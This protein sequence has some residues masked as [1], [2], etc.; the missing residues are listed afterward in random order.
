M[1]AASIKY[2]FSTICESLYTEE[3]IDV[4]LC[5]HLMKLDFTNS[6]EAEFFRYFKNSFSV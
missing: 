3:R 5:D 6:N 2:D 4:F 1:K